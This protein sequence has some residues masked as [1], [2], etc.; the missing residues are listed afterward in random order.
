MTLPTDRFAQAIE[1][2]DAAN[3]EDPTRAAFD[4]RECPAELLYGLRMTEWL[5]R[6]APDASEA[7]QLAVRCQHIRRWEIPRSSYPMTRPGYLQWRTTLG[8]F[9]ADIA[10]DILRSVGYDEG[11]VARVQSLVRKEGLKSDPETQTLEDVACLVF[12]E[13]DYVPFARGHE[14]EKVIHILKR[15]WRK[16]SD[17]GR[18]AA[19]ALA[20][21]LPPD[22][23]A[24]V[25]QAVT[26]VT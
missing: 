14:A 11:T 26:G 22:E 5:R 12:L 8:R 2:F 1:R 15:T 20:E 19:L 23:R 25:E 17:R 10:A 21:T 9:H 4:G 6:L 13:N 7:L 24:L 3:R 16:M 18:Q